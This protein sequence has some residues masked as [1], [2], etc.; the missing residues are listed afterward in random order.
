MSSP[1]TSSIA[2]REM[3]ARAPSTAR[4]V[5]TSSARVLVSCGRPVGRRAQALTSVMSG[6]LGG[7]ES[8]EATMS[9]WMASR[10]FLASWS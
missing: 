5:P 9:E 10:S 3:S 8:R 7:V 6:W 4:S 1:L 2:W